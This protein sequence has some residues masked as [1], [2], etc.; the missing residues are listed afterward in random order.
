MSFSLPRW[1]GEGA[2]GHRSL[3]L[4]FCP[5]TS[6]FLGFYRSYLRLPPFYSL[7]LEEL[8]NKVPKFRPIGRAVVVSAGK[9]DQAAFGG[10]PGQFPAVSE[11]DDIIAAAVK[12][13]D[14]A[15]KGG[16]FRTVVKDIAHK[17]GWQQHAAGKGPG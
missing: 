2:S 12:D 16:E 4:K 11:G 10:C 5:G 9:F 8:L 1:N 6:F 14:R 17:K 7:I 13:Q 15:R 3:S